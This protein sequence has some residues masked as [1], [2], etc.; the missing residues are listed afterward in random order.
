MGPKEICISGGEGLNIPL[1]GGRQEAL[2]ALP[3]ELTLQRL[4]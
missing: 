2:E 4:C 1:A 3:A